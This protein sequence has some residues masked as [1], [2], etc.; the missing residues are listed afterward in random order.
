MA[1]LVFSR[2]AKRPCGRSGGHK[3]TVEGDEVR[4]EAEMVDIVGRIVAPPKMST[5]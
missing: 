1:H 3:E 5:S 2:K 4:E